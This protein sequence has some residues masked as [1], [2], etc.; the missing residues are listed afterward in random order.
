[1]SGMAELIER[2]E[3][4]TGPDRELDE[5][6]WCATEPAIVPLIPHWTKSQRENLTPRFT[7]SLDAAVALVER[8]L[9]GWKKQIFE[10]YSGT[11]IARV[12][13]PRRETFST[14]YMRER[15]PDGSPNGSIAL[16]LALLRALSEDNT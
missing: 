5:A 16:L 14:D 8:C 13:S 12:S 2:L 15:A 11:W 10:S 7:D 6:I 1:M 4:A 3:K 9:P